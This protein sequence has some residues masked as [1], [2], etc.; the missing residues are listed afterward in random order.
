M[1]EISFRRSNFRLRMID[2]KNNRSSVIEPGKFSY[3]NKIHQKQGHKQGTLRQ[4]P[5]KII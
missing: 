5:Q 2:L 1:V 4:Q 3:G